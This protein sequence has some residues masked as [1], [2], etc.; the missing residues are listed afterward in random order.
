MKFQLFQEYAV[1]RSE[2]ESLEEKR[3]DL[4]EKLIKQLD[5]E[6]LDTVSQPFGTFAKV[7]RTKW[8]Y[9]PRLK[10]LEE[11]QKMVLNAAKK[12]EQEEGTAAKIEEVGFMFK[13]PSQ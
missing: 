3:R 4:E 6:N 5:K 1:V 7:Y 9:T 12:T 8:T 10:A 13:K 2:M 11:D